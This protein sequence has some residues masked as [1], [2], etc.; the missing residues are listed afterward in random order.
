MTLSEWLSRIT[1]PNDTLSLLTL[2]AGG[3][4]GV[5][6]LL[7]PPPPQAGKR[8]KQHKMPINEFVNRFRMIVSLRFILLP[9]TIPS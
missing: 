7:L 1:L 4:G 6:L 9:L 8:I 3:R 5:L 2:M